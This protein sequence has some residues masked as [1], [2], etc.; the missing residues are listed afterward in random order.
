MTQLNDTITRI[1]HKFTVDSMGDL[2]GY[3]VT[4]T[5]KNF[6]EAIKAELETHFPNADIYVEGVYGV[7]GTVPNATQIE[8]ETEDED[9]IDEFEAIQRIETHRQRVWDNG[10][11]EWVEA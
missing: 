3:D 1:D 9:G 2:D 8:Y 6:E 5:V 7:S 4:A 11:F 10:G